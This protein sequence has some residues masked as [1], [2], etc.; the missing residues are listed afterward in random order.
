MEYTTYIPERNETNSPPSISSQLTELKAEHEHHEKWVNEILKKAELDKI[1]DIKL[2]RADLDHQKKLIDGL[3]KASHLRNCNEA[4]SSKVYDIV[5]PNFSSQPFS[6]AC[7]A[8]TQGGNWTVILRR[9]DGSVNFNRTWNAFKKGFGD[10][11]GE[12][13][14][15]LD[16]I[17]AM[18]AERNQELLVVLEDFEGTESFETYDSFAIGDEDEQYVLHKLGKANGTA[19]DSLRLHYG[20][21]FSSQDR[22]NDIGDGHCANDFNGAWWHQFCHRSNLMGK[23]NDTTEGKGVI[24][25]DFRGKEYSLKRAVMMI[26]PG[27]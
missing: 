22:D 13:F 15:G 19:G 20:M 1:S 2:L 16:K 4:R 27:K 26:R 14:L 7:D 23:Y 9:M 17:H 8:E 21:K 6:V 5:I 18:T 3:L 25:Q 24:W 11:G 10:L 12:F